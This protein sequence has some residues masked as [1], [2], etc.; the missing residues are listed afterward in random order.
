M[1]VVRRRPSGQPVSYEPSAS[2]VD[3][4]KAFNKSLRYVQGFKTAIG[5]SASVP[6][7]ISLNSAGRMLL[8]IS[9][10]GST[11]TV[12]LNDVKVTMVVNNNNVLLD[13]CVANLNPTKVTGFLF[14][15]IPQPLNG[16]DVISLVFTNNSGVVVD[17]LTNIFYVP[18]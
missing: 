12:D 10:I 15:P 14:F 8:G 6:Q 2:Q 3:Q 1:R 5:A 18:R 4:T 17:I 16:N 13:A 9:L 11:Q 7:N